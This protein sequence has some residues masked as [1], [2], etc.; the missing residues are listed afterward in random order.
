MF[1]DCP[2]KKDDRKGKGKAIKKEVTS[3][4]V[5]YEQD[6]MDE[7]YIYATEI[8]FYATA[9]TTRLANLKPHSSLEGM[10]YLN[11]KEAQILFD[12]GT[13]G[14]NIVS[15]IFVVTYGIPCIEMAKL[16]KIHMAMKR[17]RSKSQKEYSV[18]ISVGKMEVPNTKMIIGNLVK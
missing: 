3:H 5:E 17:S 12:I 2:S 11:G 15:A 9:Q 14:V 4:N 8:E 7:V 1:K 10:I 18:Q 13:I 16:I 6:S